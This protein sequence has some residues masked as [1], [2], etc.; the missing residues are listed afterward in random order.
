MRRAS[1]GTV[2]RRC[3]VR[4]VAR[5][6]TMLVVLVLL[7]VMLIGG[8]ALARL[9]EVGTLAS[10]NTAYRDAAVQASEVGLNTAFR[11]LRDDLSQEDRADGSWYWP[12]AQ[13]TDAQG[14]PQ[15][16][17]D[18]A[19][20]IAVGPYTVAYVAERMCMGSLPLAEPLRQCLVKQIPP[21]MESTDASK[22][23]LDPP[24][25]AQF[26]LTVRVTGPKGITS[27]VQALVTKGN[28]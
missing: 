15:L 4:K 13:A 22:E 25:A 12:T 1:G 14:I 8:V 23:R 17:F 10:G 16:D 19:P 26:R 18:A 2:A 11:R 21:D 9:T 5:G 28:A 24:Y 7:T 3:V 6:M 27:W 20:H